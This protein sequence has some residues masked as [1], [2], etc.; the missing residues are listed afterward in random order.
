MLITKAEIS[1][2]TKDLINEANR[3]L[4]VT[5]NYKNLPNNSTVTSNELVIDA[6]DKRT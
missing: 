1:C 5:S 2:E 4:N 6:M 3:Q